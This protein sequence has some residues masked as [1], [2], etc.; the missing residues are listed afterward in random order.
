MRNFYI[1]ILAVAAAGGVV[2]YY[3]MRGGTPV[4]EPV[5]LGDLEQQELIALAQP[6]GVYGDPDAP[7]TIMEFADYQCGACKQFGLFVK[8]QVDLAYIDTGRA[9][10]VFHDFPI[11]SL[12]AHAFVAARAARCAGDQDRYFEYHDQ[13][14]HTQED[15]APLS[16][17]VGHFKDLAKELQLDTRDFN[18]CLQS[19]R[20]ADVV[21]ANMRLGEA[22]VVTA[23]PT[24]FVHREGSDLVRLGGS[25]FLDVEHAIEGDG[26]N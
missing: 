1:I 22:L 14:F 6:A 18:A 7:V 3:A 16:S 2:L 21:T 13:V 15:W 23:T 8:P 24:L 26:E 20:H 9:K 4:V 10:L 12:H 25:G 11:L 17:P 5:D 19:D